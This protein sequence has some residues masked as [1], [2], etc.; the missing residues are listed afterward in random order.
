MKSG[1][2]AAQQDADLLLLCLITALAVNAEVRVEGSLGE[3]AHH[4]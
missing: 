1:V 3:G 2:Q 4:A